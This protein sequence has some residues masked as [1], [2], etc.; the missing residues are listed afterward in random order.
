M[1]KWRVNQSKTKDKKGITREK[2]TNEM[3]KT[4][5]IGKINKDDNWLFFNRIEKTLARLVGG[6]ENSN[7]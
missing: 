4:Q 6:G 2:K 7:Y 1:T 3:W 5:T